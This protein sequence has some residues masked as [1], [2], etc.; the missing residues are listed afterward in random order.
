MKKIFL[1]IKKDSNKIDNEDID[2]LE[3]NR[4]KIVENANNYDKQVIRV[5]KLLGV[6]NSKTSISDSSLASEKE[7]ICTQIRKELNDIEKET[8]KFLYKIRK[9]DQTHRQNDEQNLDKEISKD[10]PL[11][12]KEESQLTFIDIENNEE[13]LARRKKSL[14]A[15]YEL[16]TKM[17]EV[18][19]DIVKKIHDEGESLDKIEINVSNANENII[20]AG[21]EI[22]TADELSKRNNGRMIIFVIISIVL[23]LLIVGVICLIV[24]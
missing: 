22:K 14:L 18:S 20:K 13:F 3:N 9:F 23:I 4:Q 7:S 19:D 1:N 6:L 12:N 11:L 16:S 24:L 21:E 17:K 15:I 5:T 10:D 8:S 2:Y